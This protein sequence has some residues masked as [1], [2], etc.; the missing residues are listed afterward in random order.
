MVQHVYERCCLCSSVDEVFIAT[1][2]EKIATTARK[3]GSK[4]VMTSKKID[5]PSLRVAVASESMGLED[6]DIVVVV[7][8]DEPLVH[9]D[10]VSLAI[11]P[12]VENPDIHVSNLV[13]EIV[14]DEEWKDPN[15]IKVVVD[16]NMNALYM[17]RSPIPYFGHDGA[18]GQRLKQV[19]IM[20]FKWH[21]MKKFNHQ[22]IPTPNEIT[23]SIEMN[24][25]IDHGIK[26]K[27]VKSDFISKSVDTSSDLRIVEKIMKNDEIYKYIENT[28]IHDRSKNSIKIETI[29]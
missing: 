4:V 14:S 22:L 17:S 1:C 7:Q 11:R 23:E 6:D 16:R 3:F 24:R 29:L 13:S 9:P 10:M 2:D 27:M 18:K 19:C 12:L 8:G 15:E 28:G 21:F 5:R 26:V 25:A 20:P